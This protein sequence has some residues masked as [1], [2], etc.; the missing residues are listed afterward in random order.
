MTIEASK[1]D[2]ENRCDFCQRKLGNEARLLS[3]GADD[4]RHF[5][6]FACY[7]RWQERVIKDVI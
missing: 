2:R 6:S 7:D 4:P 5:C 3:G 1:R